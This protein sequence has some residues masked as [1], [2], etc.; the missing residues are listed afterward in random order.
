[1]L[2][3]EAI[4]TIDSPAASLARQ[5]LLTAIPRRG[6]GR[7]SMGQRVVLRPMLVLA[8]CTPL[9]WH[10]LHLGG[11][12]VKQGVEAE[13]RNLV[14]WEPTWWGSVGLPLFTEL[15]RAKGFSETA[16]TPALRGNWVGP[17]A[18][19]NGFTEH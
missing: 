12:P 15:P 11:F 13:G 6:S 19:K 5:L 17:G 9:Y 8:S 18:I 1:M 2:Y 10:Q 7:E 3:Q 4:G 16:L 14:N